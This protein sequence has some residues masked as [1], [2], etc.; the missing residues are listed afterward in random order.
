MYKK[1][2]RTNCFTRSLVFFFLSFFL[3]PQKSEIPSTQQLRKKYA[4][5]GRQEQHFFY[6]LHSVL[7]GGA[8]ALFQLFQLIFKN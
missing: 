3:V 5:W 2:D 6:I 4:I 8:F 7:N 1:K